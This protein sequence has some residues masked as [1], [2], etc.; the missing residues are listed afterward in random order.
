MRITHETIGYIKCGVC[1]S[2]L[3]SYDVNELKAKKE[4]D[5][6]RASTFKYA[7]GTSVG[8][9]DYIKCENCGIDILNLIRTTWKELQ[10][11]NN[12]WDSENNE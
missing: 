9:N 4:E 8:S 11:S 2:F 5:F 6:I 10:N 7:D 3:V 12:E 1:N